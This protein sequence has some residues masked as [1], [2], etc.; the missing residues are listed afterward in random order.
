MQPPFAHPVACCWELLRP[1]ARSLKA[2]WGGGGALTITANSLHVQTKRQYFYWLPTV[3]LAL[4]L[5]GNR[6]LSFLT[7][8]YSMLFSVFDWKFTHTL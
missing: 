6:D 7:M 2:W 8:V 4:S 1:S 5:K 3:P